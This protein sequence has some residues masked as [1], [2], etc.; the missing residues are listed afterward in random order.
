LHHDRVRKLSL[1]ARSGVQEVWVVTPFPSSVEVFHLDGSTYRLMAS[2]G[3]EDT[4]T[5]PLFPDLQIELAGI[6]D[7]PVDPDEE[8]HLIKEGRPPAYAAAQ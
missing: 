1:Y 3:K 7:F 6:F 8:L 5:S 2:Y 4:L